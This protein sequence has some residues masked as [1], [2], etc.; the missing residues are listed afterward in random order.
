MT[1]NLTLWTWFYMNRLDSTLYGA[2]Q[3]L[4]FSVLQCKNR[5][6]DETYESGVDA[7]SL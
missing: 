4:K 1:V 6:N 5:E 7:I 2:G 3:L